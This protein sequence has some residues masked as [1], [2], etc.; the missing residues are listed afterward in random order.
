VKRIHSVTGKSGKPDLRTENTRK[1]DSKDLLPTTIST[2]IQGTFIAP[3]VAIALNDTPVKNVHVPQK[4]TRT[5]DCHM[6]PIPTILQKIEA[7]SRITEEIGNLCIR[8]QGFHE[9]RT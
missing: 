2:R 1:Y 7:N 5:S 4:V 3:F 9:L 8:Q 6:P